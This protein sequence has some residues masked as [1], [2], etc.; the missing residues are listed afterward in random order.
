MLSYRGGANRHSESI[1]IVSSAAYCW[2]NHIAFGKACNRWMIMK[3]THGHEKW[4]YSI[5]YHFTSLPI[6]DYRSLVTTFWYVLYRGRFAV[7]PHSTLS[8]TSLRNCKMMK[9]YIMVHL[10]FA[11][12]WQNQTGSLEMVKQALL[13]ICKICEIGGFLPHKGHTIYDH[14][15]LWH[16]IIHHGFTFS[17]WT[18]PWSGRGAR[19][20]SLQTLKYWK[21]RGFGVF[22]RRFFAHTGD[23]RVLYTD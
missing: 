19:Y 10:R 14:G 1:K 13:D 3:V 22:F 12:L 6:W 8:H 5:R 4:R 16:D 7:V 23:S 2:K 20:R 21:C 18:R 15:E 11:L 9:L 17:C